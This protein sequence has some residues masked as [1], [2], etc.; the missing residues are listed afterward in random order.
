MTSTSTCFVI[1][2]LFDSLNFLYITRID[3]SLNNLICNLE[4]SFDIRLI[5]SILCNVYGYSFHNC[6]HMD[7]ARKSL[8][9]KWYP[10]SFD[11]EDVLFYA[12][13][14]PVQIRFIW[15]PF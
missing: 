5:V 15:Q 4:T 9:L 8:M 3:I 1:L 10:L 12:L 13:Q 2:P 14:G 7:I 6:T 11:R